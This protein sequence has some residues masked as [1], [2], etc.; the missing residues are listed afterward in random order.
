M[1]ISRVSGDLTMAAG[2]CDEQQNGDV[3][4][5]SVKNNLFVP[6]AAAGEEVCSLNLSTVKVFNQLKSGF[7]FFYSNWQR[8]DLTQRHD[9]S[10]G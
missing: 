7:F 4:A 10:C 6:T 8:S 5:H 9:E 3:L 2:H 1:N